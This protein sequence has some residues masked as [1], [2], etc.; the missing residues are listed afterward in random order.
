MFFRDSFGYKFV[1]PR[2]LKKRHRSHGNNVP[3]CHSLRDVQKKPI[4][5]LEIKDQ[6]SR[7]KAKKKTKKVCAFVLKTLLAKFEKSLAR[8]GKNR[9][10]QHSSWR[11]SSIW[12]YRPGLLIQRYF[13]N[14]G[15]QKFGGLSKYTIGFLGRSGLVEILNST[16]PPPSLL[17]EY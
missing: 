1:C 11:H 12:N 14:F 8:R 4:S 2:F 9:I 13:E 7:S 15:A 10:S 17:F 16:P 5:P 3:L 6:E